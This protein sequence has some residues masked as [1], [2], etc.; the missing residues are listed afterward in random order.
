LGQAVA[1][2]QT[3]N[4]WCVALQTNDAQDSIKGLFS[5]LPAANPQ[6]QEFTKQRNFQPMFMRVGGSQTLN[7]PRMFI[8]QSA[9]QV[10]A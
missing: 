9:C 3:Q 6:I 7:L 5:R 1:P 8:G 2:S 10:R 4:E